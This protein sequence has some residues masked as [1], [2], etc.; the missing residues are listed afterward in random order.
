MNSP[1][2]TTQENLMKAIETGEVKMHSRW[3][4]VIQATFFGAGV[5]I[6]VGMIVYTV[7][8]AVFVTE[9]SGVYLAPRYGIEGWLL[10]ARSIPWL[11][12]LSAFVLVGVLELLARR[13]SFVY[14]RPLAY[15]FVGIV[16]V[17]SV[18]GALVAQTSFHASLSELSR[19]RRLPFA[20]TWYE[21]YDPE[22]VRGMYRGRIVALNGKSFILENRM[23]RTSTI[24][25]T[26]NTRLPDR[27]LSENDRVIVIG[28]GETSTIAAWG[29]RYMP[30]PPP[31][32]SVVK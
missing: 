4:F 24:M 31:R 10:F 9:Q 30:T 32:P 18:S 29:V 26:A 22:Q 17:V 7:S 20:R 23:G 2:S 8:L 16:A 25:I 21:Y 28:F 27:A 3:Y 13:F 15:S 14:S 19:G 1:T 11:L 5:F 12:I 6:I